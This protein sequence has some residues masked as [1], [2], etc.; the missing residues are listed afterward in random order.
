MST[1]VTPGSPRAIN[2]PIIS[3]CASGE[4][5]YCLS[6]M[7]LCHDSQTHTSSSFPSSSQCFD[8]SC[9][10]SSCSSV[11]C[12]CSPNLSQFLPGHAL[13]FGFPKSCPPSASLLTF[14]QALSLSLFP[15]CQINRQFLKQANRFITATSCF[16]SGQSDI[17]NLN[18]F[19]DL[20]S[21]TRLRKLLQ[22]LRSP[23]QNPQQL[24]IHYNVDTGVRTSQT[25]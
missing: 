21:T 11:T 5:V 20:T 8:C 4:V 15:E 9:L 1:H 23:P 12:W 16:C 2:S 18:S 17:A 14:L 6:V 19:S 3:G 10:L 24:S 25:C 22:L 13:P 7:S